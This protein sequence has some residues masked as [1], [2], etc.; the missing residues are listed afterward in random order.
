MPLRKPA[1]LMGDLTR[2]VSVWMACVIKMH[3]HRVLLVI[4]VDVTAMLWNTGLEVQAVS[5]VVVVY[6]RHITGWIKTK[7]S[8]T[9]TDGLPLWNP[10]PCVR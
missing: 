3:S 7:E 9:N 8:H 5:H 2:S 10:A 1:P 6:Q 4:R